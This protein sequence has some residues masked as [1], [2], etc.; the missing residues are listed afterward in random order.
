LPRAN[1][2]I[3]IVLAFCVLAIG[4]LVGLLLTPT[5]V[6]VGL[7]NGRDPKSAKV[8]EQTFSDAQPVSAV[9]NLSSIQEVD[10]ATEGIVTA[11]NCAPDQ[12][13]SSGKAVFSADGVPVIAFATSVPMWRDIVGGDHGDDVVA[14]QKELNRLGYSVAV[15]GIYNFATRLAMADL[16]HKAGATLPY[17]GGLARSA[18][19][20]IPDPT[21]AVA[22]CAISVGQQITGG[23]TVASLP[24]TLESITISNRPSH[25]VAGDRVL[26][27]GQFVVPTN[28]DGTVVDPALLKIV[29]ES[30]L[31]PSLLDQQ[32][33]QSLKVDWNLKNPITV[34]AVP[35]GS[36]Y[37]QNG[38]SACV[39]TGKTQRRI[40]VIS[41]SLGQSLVT[42]ARGTVPAT[43]DLNPHQRPCN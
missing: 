37:G 25:P 24:A 8:T 39:Q 41:S 1:A 18:L 2:G 22:G 5:P 6:P 29:T 12:K 40:L 38:T 28:T 43:V 42:F 34:A 3:A 19:V 26:D 13:L 7:S 32:K 16:L 27:F 23:M 9:L 31:Y 35:P 21:V 14:V 15:N 4:V 33:A 36:I 20:W 10:S 17:S 30:T 11:V